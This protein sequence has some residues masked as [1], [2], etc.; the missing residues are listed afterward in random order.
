M[1]ELIAKS[2]VNYIMA[3]LDV[4]SL[5]TSIPHDLAINSIIEACLD[6]KIEFSISK[7]A[8]EELISFCLFNNCFV[9]NCIFYSQH[10][11]TPMGSSLPV[12][13]AEIVKQKIEK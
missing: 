13:I 11:G 1:T 5:Y 8:L 2:E 9:F 12:R 6:S 7:S 3:S 4:I 10:R